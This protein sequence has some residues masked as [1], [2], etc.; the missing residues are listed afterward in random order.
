MSFSTGLVDSFYDQHIKK[1]WQKATDQASLQIL[2]VGTASTLAARPHDDA[3]YSSWNNDQKMSSAAADFGD[4][5]GSGIPGLFIV[6]VQYWFDDNSNH[7]V[8]HARSLAW[9]TLSVQTLKYAFK[10]NRPGGSEDR[11]SFPSGHTTTSFATATS[12][13]YAY[14]WKAALIAY[15]MAAFVAS[16]R[17]AKG[18]HWFSDVVAG[19]FLGYWVGRAGFYKGQAPDQ[20]KLVL[21]PDLGPEEIALNLTYSF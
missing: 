19:A 2:L 15:P 20:Q 13:T 21:F 9:G 7:A 1:F 17:L 11:S 12:L 16:S 4:H 3:I 18:T 8:S 14:G 5:L 6:G 10:R